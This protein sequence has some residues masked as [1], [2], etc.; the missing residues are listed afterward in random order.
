MYRKMKHINIRDAKSNKRIEL[1]NIDNK[2]NP[3]NEIVSLQTFNK[4]YASLQIFHKE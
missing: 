3:V 2:L 4:H 1:I